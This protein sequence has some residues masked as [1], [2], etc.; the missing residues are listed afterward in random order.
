MERKL[1]SK[2]DILL[3]TILFVLC[4]GLLIVFRHGN[5][6]KT[7]TIYFNNDIVETVNLSENTEKKIIKTG[8]EGKCIICCENNEIYFLS[9]DCPDKLC[10][11]SKHLSKNG[12]FA[13]CLPQKVVITVSSKHKNDS[14]D[15]ISY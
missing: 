9:S 3:L 5:D 12:D 10:V 7:A 13:A 1:I 8:S 2:N 11:K 14:P 15:I 4:L 6:K